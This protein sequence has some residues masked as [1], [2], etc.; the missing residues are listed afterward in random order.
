MAMILLRIYIFCVISDHLG[1]ATLRMIPKSARGDEERL[2]STTVQQPSE[3]QSKSR[4]KGRIVESD[5]GNVMRDDA[6]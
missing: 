3:N 5:I 2:G 6:S 1:R 4:K